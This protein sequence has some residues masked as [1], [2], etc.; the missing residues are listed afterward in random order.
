VQS[1]D[2]LPIN[3]SSSLMISFGAQSVPTGNTLPFRTEPVL[4]QLT[5]RAGK[6]LRLLKSTFKQSENEIPVEYSDGKYVINLKTPLETS[7]LYLK[8]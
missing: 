8:K 5:I 3:Q 1:V 2:G 7:W 6:G 4:G